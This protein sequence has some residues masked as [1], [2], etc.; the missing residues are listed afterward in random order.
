M[1]VIAE[2]ANERFFA[3]WAR[4]E[5]SIGRQRI[6]RAK[7]SKALNEFTRG[8]IDGDHAFGFELA[9][10]HMN[11]PLVGPGGAQAIAGQIGTLSDAH[12]GVSDQQKGIAAEIV[13]AKELLL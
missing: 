8:S 13:T 12:A 10:G 6:Q 1:Q 9:E 3:V 11:G 2:S 5:P 7:E 4:Q